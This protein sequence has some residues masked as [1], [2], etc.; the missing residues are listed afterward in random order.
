MEIPMSPAKL[1][2]MENAPAVKP[3]ALCER[4]TY[5]TARLAA[6]T[7]RH[8]AQRLAEA[9]LGAGQ[10]AILCCLDEFGPQIQKE[11]AARLEID[12]GDLVAFVDDV[13]RAG[14]VERTRDPRD[15]RRQVLTLTGRG[16]EVLDGAERGLDR[17]ADEAFRPLTQA[18]RAML[19][20][21]M[22]RVLAHAD[23]AAWPVRAPRIEGISRG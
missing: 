12:P 4:T 1:V 8:C 11:V 20:G 22:L 15:R 7:R 10:H 9:G 21:L 5:L 14:L 19:H 16:K 6:A 18:E 3:A 2:D 13:Q 17:A 23:P